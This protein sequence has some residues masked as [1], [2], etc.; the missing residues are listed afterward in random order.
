MTLGCLACGVRAVRGQALDLRW[1]VMAAAFGVLAFSIRQFAVAAPVAVLIVFILADRR[2]GALVAACTTGLILAITLFQGSLEG[3]V[4]ATP[5]F[6]AVSGGRLQLFRPSP[7][8]SCRS[9][10]APSR[11]DAAS[12]VEIRGSVGPWQ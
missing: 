7:S 8:S 1:A 6:P 5:S 4:G 12:V 2:R 10:F 11:C 3:Q 9:V